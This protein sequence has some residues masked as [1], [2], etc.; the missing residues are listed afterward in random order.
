MNFTELLY[1]FQSEQ[2]THV[3]LWGFSTSTPLP[4]KS[5]TSAEMNYQ[6]ISFNLQLSQS[7]WRC[8]MELQT[9]V[10][11]ASRCSEENI[12]DM[13]LEYSFNSYFFSPEFPVFY[14]Y[15]RKAISLLIYWCSYTCTCSIL[16]CVHL[17]FL[18]IKDFWAPRVDTGCSWT[19]G[20]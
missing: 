12:T 11:K 10:L 1:C 19:C 13:L 20:L 18:C 15:R 4:F 3:C 14:H 8:Q 7:L 6:L 17:F 16:S 9:A 5:S 2:D